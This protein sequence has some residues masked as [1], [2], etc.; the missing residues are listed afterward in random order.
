MHC[1]GDSYDYYTAR[2]RSAKCEIGDLMAEN[3]SDT[4][5]L[6]ERHLCAVDGDVLQAAHL[7]D[8]GPA[9][10]V[11]MCDV[12]GSWVQMQ[13]SAASTNSRLVERDDQLAFR[14]FA[15]LEWR[16]SRAEGPCQPSVVDLENV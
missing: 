4:E 3:G 9:V 5:R 1:D 7:R 12:L 15:G 11:R 14:H 6:L 10:I 13:S 8:C 2:K 16:L